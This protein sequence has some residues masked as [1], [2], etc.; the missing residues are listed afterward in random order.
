M[1]E[2]KDDKDERCR[3]GKQLP[4]IGKVCRVQ[5]EQHGEQL[6][7]QMLALIACRSHDD[8]AM[9]VVAPRDTP[10]TQEREVREDC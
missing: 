1:P 6:D 5:R 10:T 2:Q 3:D 8:D 7:K 9:I 4:I